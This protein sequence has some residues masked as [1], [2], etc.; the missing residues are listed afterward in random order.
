MFSMSIMSL[1]SI[2]LL[3]QIL[4]DELISLCMHYCP[5][6]AAL[7]EEQGEFTIGMNSY[8]FIFSTATSYSYQQL[9]K[10][11]KDSWNYLAKF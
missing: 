9:C 6:K 3:Q 1:Q 7:K 10:I 8:A 4:W 2:K 5:A 11:W